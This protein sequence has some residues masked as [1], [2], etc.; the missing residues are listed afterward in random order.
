[1]VDRDTV[2]A[3]SIRDADGDLNDWLAARGA[4]AVLI[5][6][7][8]YIYGVAGSAGTLGAMIEELAAALCA[9]R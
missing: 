4:V 1:V 7:D 5:R 6:P 8:F 2:D 9:A 3:G